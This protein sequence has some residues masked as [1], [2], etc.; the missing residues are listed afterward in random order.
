MNI[1]DTGA[2]AEELSRGKIPSLREW[3]QILKLA[4]RLKEKRLKEEAAERDRIRCEEEKKKHEKL[5]S[6]ITSMDL[7]VS[8]DNPYAGTEAAAGI[9]VQSAPD[10]LIMSIHNLG[11]VDI[12]YIALICGQSYK[13]V[14]TTLKGSIFQNPD[15]WQECF[16]KGWE[17][18]DSYLSGNL[19]HK[20]HEAEKA[21]KKY[22]DYFFDNLAAIKAVLPPACSHEDIYITLGSPWV[23]PGIIDLFMEHLFG[24][25]YI[26]V[27]GVKKKQSEY[28]STKVKYEEIT[29]TWYIPEKNRYGGS[30]KVKR[31]YGTSKIS[32]LY[33]LEKSLNMQIIKIYD[34]IPSKSSKAGK[35]KVLNQDETINACEKQQKI[36]MAFR[37]WVWRDEARKK[38]LEQIFY[39]TYGTCLKRNFNGSFLAFPG[40]S[41]K[42]EIRPYQKDAVAKI[43]FTPNVLLAHEVG[44]GKTYV[45]IAAGMELR[46]MGISKKNMYVVPNNILRQW[47]T[48]FLELYP[49]AGI[50]VIAPKDFTPDKR[51]LVLERIQ[52]DDYDAIILSY[53]SFGLI[54]LSREHYKNAF[55][56]Q[57]KR[58]EDALSQNKDVMGKLWKRK[59]K[60]EETMKQIN[61][62]LNAS[63][64]SICFDELG[65]NTLFVDEAHN[66]KNLTIQSKIDNILGLNKK[67]SNKCNEMLEKV[68]CIQKNNDGRGV[69]FATGTPVTNSI[70]D[71]FVMQTYLQ[72]GELQLLNIDLF[73]NW[74]GMFAE[75][76]NDFEIN[77]TTSGYRI[78]TRFARFHNLP[79]LTSLLAQTAD[80]LRCPHSEE[81]PAFSGYTDRLI[82]RTKELENYIDGLSRRADD[83]KNGLVP[84][85]V[86]NMLKITTDGRKA[87]LDIRLVDNKLPFNRQSKAAVCSE[88][89][90]YIYNKTAKNKS[91]QII[92]C[93]TSIPK[94]N[95]NMYDEIKRLLIGANIPPKDIAFI[96]D[97]DTGKEK[98]ELFRKMQA[99]EIRILVGSTFKLGIGVNVQRKLIAIHHLDIPWRPA[100]MVQREGR[101]LRQGNQNK[102][103]AILRYI[104]EGSFDAYSWQLLET[105]Q[106]FIVDLLS[107]FAAT[108]SSGDIDNTVLNYA[109]V[110]ALA[111]GD[112]LIKKRIEAANELM[113]I[114]ALNKNM[115]D[116]RLKLEMEH[117]A[118][119][120]RLTAI[121]Q[122]IEN[123][124]SD[125]NRYQINMIPIKQMK[126]RDLLRKALHRELNENIL[127]GEERPLFEYQGF[128]VI[129]PQNMIEEKPFVWLKG[130]GRYMVE[131]SGAET[132]NLIRIDNRLNTLNELIAEQK[133]EFEKL[134]ARQKEIKDELSKKESFADEIA[135][136]KASLEKIDKE[137]GVNKK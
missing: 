36:I 26:E 84:R 89:T 46:R 105:K 94:D 131:L 128:K 57:L 77:V 95:F 42:V 1:T 116:S 48:M 69:V 4:E 63:L 85:S 103:I 75:K 15:T 62:V 35:K 117:R 122:L 49:N 16:Y 134:I 110:K 123:A 29:G 87:A 53:S 112:P 5:I 30:V 6:E 22:A 41:D 100:D 7:P 54:P 74:A 133:D 115:V 82:G 32:A 102:K 97:Y 66:Y 127:C 19:M 20:Y 93:D 11:R 58:I 96:H 118:L 79:E 108:R 126:N 121:R 98:E 114:N 13:E 91:S 70:T 64:P 109:E 137:L 80:F 132:G 44:A 78:A 12:E 106:K 34:E 120:G 76:T 124:Q 125:L 90:A 119:P 111:I 40:K 107:G 24:E 28:Y 59:S 99:G 136:L 81:I 55:D 135:E 83:I 73:D 60:L 45:M 21:N 67:G 68:R 61:A 37:D 88:W 50:L 38:Q 3:M 9:S 27:R 130:Q 43:L 25:C 23:P 72:Y 92:F 39:E 101:I 14:I 17:T 47:Q 86:D 51:E 8:W 65:I 129:L 113:R 31:T 56:E 104:S 2:L 33:I 52:S 10:G 18:A 71:L